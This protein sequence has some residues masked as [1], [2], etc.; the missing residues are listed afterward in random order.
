MF[1]GYDCRVS[2]VTKTSAEK[3]REE[4]ASI[5]RQCKS[6]GD[7]FSPMRS[8]RQEFC[9]KRCGN[10]HHYA[11][12]DKT[13]SIP[14]CAKTYVARGYC[15]SHYNQ[16]LKPDRHKKKRLVPCA[17][18]GVEVE[19]HASN[20]NRRAVCSYRCRAFLTRGYY[21]PSTELVGPVH[22]MFG[23]ARAPKG[24]VNPYADKP[25]NPNRIFAQGSC[26]WCGESF[27]AES[28]NSW[29][30]PRYCSDLCSKKYHRKVSKK[31]N[32][33]FA[34]ADRVRFEI[35]ERDGWLCQ[36]CFEPT[37]RRYEHD[38][39]L[40]PTLDHIVAQANGGSDDP[41]NLRL[42]HAICNSERG[43]GDGAGAELLGLF[44]F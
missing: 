34:V 17:A 42:A 39:P 6:C 26:R 20:G 21:P 44:A 31:R 36:L 33:R 43:T 11:N 38:D 24:Y 5:V 8:V 41:E 2:H 15:A 27:V 18:C 13:C 40:S 32:G 16:I 25:G 12:S 23:P 22:K 28:R 7:S 29:Q 30:L 35:Y 37:S 19:K 10:K 3:R 9:S 4:R 14:G 1:C